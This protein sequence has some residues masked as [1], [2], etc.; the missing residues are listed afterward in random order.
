MSKILSIHSFRGGTGKSNTA[1]N[2]AALMVQRG[3]RVAIVDTDIPSPGVH[4]PLGLDQDSLAYTLNDYLWGQ[5]TIEQAAYPVAEAE[6]G[7]GLYLIPSSIKT[8]AIT[9]VLREGY[10]VERLNDG[11]RNVIGALDLD[12]LVIDTHPGLNSETLMSVAISDILIIILRPDRQDYQGT[13]VTVEVGRRLEVPAMYLLVNKV[14]TSYDFEAVRRQV[15][16][17]FGCP[18]AGVLPQCDEMM[19]LSSAGLFI[20]H[21]PEH[22]LSLE[23]RRVAEVVC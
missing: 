22:P 10:D 21:Y 17:T 2:L 16:E 5:C 13:A 14:L 3:L 4:A 7:P 18:V 15:S 8:G 9:R 12:L 19:E 11:F 1:A 6:V 23:L 20:L